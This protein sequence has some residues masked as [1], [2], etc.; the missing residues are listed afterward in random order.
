M[1]ASSDR[2]PIPPRP[3]GLHQKPRRRLTVAALICLSLM[4]AALFVVR[5]PVR[6]VQHSF[7]LVLIY[8]ASRAWLIGSNPYNSADLDR[9][10]TQSVSD[11][12]DRPTRQQDPSLYPPATFVLMAPFAAMKW[13]AAKV[14]WMAANLGFLLML[15]LGAIRLAEF[16]LTDTGTWVLA[17][18]LLAFGAVHTGFAS[19]Q[20][21]LASTALI[22]LA[23]VNSTAGR[24]II[25]ATALGLATA[26]KPQMGALFFLCFVVDRQ[27]KALAMAVGLGLAVLL[28]GG[29]R[30]QAAGYD[31]V[32]DLL[33]SVRTFS[34]GGQGD[35]S[36]V[37]M[38]RYQ[39]VNLASLLHSFLDSRIAVKA[40]VWTCVAAATAWSYTSVR[41][42]RDRESR[43]SK[44]LFA[45]VLSLLTLLM[46]YHRYYDAV[47]LALPLAWSLARL[48]SWPRRSAQVALMLLIPLS[49]SGVGALNVLIRKGWIQPRVSDQWWWGGLVMAHQVWLLCGLTVWLLLVLWRKSRAPRGDGWAVSVGEW[50][51]G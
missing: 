45:S 47:L 33:W 7:D 22:V 15:V 36:S 18:C 46:A 40:I 16:K 27:W 30:L 41:R 1:S 38:N 39:L 28:V 4:A 20:L 11:P 31:W 9:V 29:L 43:E 5:G 19:A 3:L 17:I 44:L 8:P 49:V 13:P 35:P 48:S 37:N 21:G 6:A 2:I 23:L 34:E 42:L 25:A 12:A 10:M 50:V 14:A 24:Q 51:S 32:S 26:L